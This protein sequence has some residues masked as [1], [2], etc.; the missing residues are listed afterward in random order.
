MDRFQALRVFVRIAESGAFSKAADALNVPR[1]TATKLIQDLETH[2]GIRL[3]Q[4]TTRRVSMTPEGAIYYARASKL[5]ADLEDM[6]DS[7][8]GSKA[9]PRGR[10]RVDVGSLFANLLL[11]PALPNLQAK[12]PQLQLDLGVN[13]RPVDLIGEGVDCVIRGG[14]LPD[15]TL[16]ARRLADLDWITCA[17]PSYVRQRGKPKHPEE[18]LQ[19]PDEPGGH[20]LV[21]YFS[22]LT[23]K[24]APMHFERGDEKLLVP[25]DR[26]IAVNE[27]TAHLNAIA[28]GL[29]IGQTFRCMA[30]RLLAQGELVEVLPQ[31]TRP[32][33]RLS[34]VYPHSRNLSVK[35]RAFSDWTAELFATVDTRRQ[36][37]T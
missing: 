5:L 32:V 35:V 4:R 11:I 20:T 8:A 10:L 21:A 28:S 2:L 12:Y 14:E 3:F 7:V 9:Q 16:V 36:V 33:L 30:A 26:G 25:V 31:W 19:A 13:D 15:T 18:L 24:H 27:S 6:D 1:A 23:G 17:A 22:P 37:P 34:L 29:G